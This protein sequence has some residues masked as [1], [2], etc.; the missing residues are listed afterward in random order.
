MPHSHPK[1]DQRPG[2]AVHS[3]A[4]VHQ[5]FIAPS[6][7]FSYLPYAQQYNYQLQ[8][9]N[10]VQPAPA[11]VQAAPVVAAPV[12]AAY[13]AATF[14]AQDNLGQ[15]SFG[16]DNNH[17]AAAVQPKD[18]SLGDTPASFAHP[19]G[20]QA[21]TPVVYAAA[22]HPNGAQAATLPSP[23]VFAEKPIAAL[24]EVG[25]PVLTQQVL[26]VAATTERTTPWPACPSLSTCSR[27]AAPRGMST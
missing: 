9:T 12:V 13:T 18:L 22:A 26:Y 21:T 10:Y 4:P 15:Y 23:I 5:A 1:E 17:P 16:L 19:N 2:A 6:V 25:S 7:N 14:Y 27:T 24:E 3:A 8:P 20:V 11:I